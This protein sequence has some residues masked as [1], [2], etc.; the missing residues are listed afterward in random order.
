MGAFSFSGRKYSATS[1]VYVDE[2]IYD[3][4]TDQLVNRTEQLGIG[5]GEHRD[6]VV[7]PAIDDSALDRY[8]TITE[9]AHR[10]G[11]VRTGGSVVADDALPEGRYVEPTVVTD[12][13]HSHDLAPRSTSFRS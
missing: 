12:I 11:T 13:P 3:E 5:R 6:T 4:F 1:R 2:D 8:E 7:N 10:E 9:Q